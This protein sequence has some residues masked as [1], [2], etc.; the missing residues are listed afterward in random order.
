MHS[1]FPPKQCYHNSQKLTFNES[2]NGGVMWTDWK[3][4]SGEFTQRWICKVQHTTYNRT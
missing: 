4:L 2:Y 1:L 3:N